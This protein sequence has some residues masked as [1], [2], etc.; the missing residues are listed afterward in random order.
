[1]Y[2]TNIVFVTYDSNLPSSLVGQPLA[3]SSSMSSSQSSQ[4]AFHAC[5]ILCPH[6]DCSQQFKTEVGL[7]QHC[8]TVHNFTFSW[9]QNHC[10]TSL[11]PPQLVIQLVPGVIHVY[12]DKLTG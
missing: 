12:H 2:K 8:S 4:Y 6:V 9:S 5:Q 11:T 7:R 1:M 3:L 10:K